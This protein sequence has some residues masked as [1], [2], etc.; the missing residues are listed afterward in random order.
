MTM[1][2]CAVCRSCH[3][4]LVRHRGAETC[5]LPNLYPQLLV[6]GDQGSAG[7]R[8]LVCPL[9]ERG[10]GI[11]A[12]GLDARKGTARGKRR[13]GKLLLRQSGGLA[14]IAQ[15]TTKSRTRCA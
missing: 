5:L 2:N 9:P 14:Q 3:R 15:P 10:L 13:G 4:E 8:H 1:G 11:L 6:R 12:A 7:I